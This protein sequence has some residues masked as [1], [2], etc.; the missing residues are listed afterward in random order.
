MHIS[1]YKKIYTGTL[2]ITGVT[3]TLCLQTRTSVQDPR[4]MRSF[5]LILTS[6]QSP[7][8]SKDNWRI[9]NSNIMIKFWGFRWI[10]P[11]CQ[12][13]KSRFFCLYVHACMSVLV[14]ITVK[15]NFYFCKV[16]INYRIAGKFGREL[17]L[18]VW[19]F[20]LRPPN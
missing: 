9:Q 1:I 11:T 18:V 8:R 13:K 10:S 6:Y 15:N 4:N 12:T 19:L 7:S 17:I 5:W 20:S 2:Y 14:E 3:L 16:Y